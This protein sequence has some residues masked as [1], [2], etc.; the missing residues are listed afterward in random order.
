M[1]DRPSDSTNNC[2]SI[3]S[4]SQRIQNCIHIVA[5][6]SVEHKLSYSHIKKKYNWNKMENVYF[7]AHQ[8]EVKTLVGLINDPEQKLLLSLAHL[9]STW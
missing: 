8:A 5:N 7:L 1:V 4:G 6:H 2:V 9:K 3:G